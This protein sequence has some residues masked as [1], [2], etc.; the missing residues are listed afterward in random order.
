[1]REQL[2]NLKD[3]YD[4]REKHYNSVT[5]SKD[6]ELKLFEAKLAQQ[7]EICHQETQKARSLFF[8]WFSK[9]EIKLTLSFGLEVGCL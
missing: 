3:Q 1:M 5:K 8:H 6:L 2:K 4:L 9:I 7:T